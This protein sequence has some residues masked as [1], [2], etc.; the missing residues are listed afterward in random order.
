MSGELTGS[1]ALVEL[2]RKRADYID[3]QAGLF[4]SGTPERQAAGELTRLT[5]ENAALRAEL[6]ALHSAVRTE[7][8]A[9]LNYFG[10]AASGMKYDPVG[11]GQCT[12]C[13]KNAKQPPLTPMP[14]WSY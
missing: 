5:A 3:K 6:T 7:G 12:L 1:C 13:Q 11:S 8:E 4:F 14:S 2:L 9:A 10:Q